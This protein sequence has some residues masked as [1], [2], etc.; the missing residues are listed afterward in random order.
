MDGHQRVCSS[1]VCGPQTELELL[2]RPEIR[3]TFRSFPRAPPCPSATTCLMN[4]LSSGYEVLEVREEPNVVVA[5]PR[6]F[7]ALLIVV[8]RRGMWPQYKVRKH[9]SHCAGV[10][11]HSS[12]M[13][14]QPPPPPPFRSPMAYLGIV[15]H[16]PLFPSRRFPNTRPGDFVPPPLSQSYPSWGS[17]PLPPSATA[18][19]QHAPQSSFLSAHME[20]CVSASV[21]TD[22]CSHAGRTG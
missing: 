9:Y 11:S 21:P 14:L 4:R 10:V 18:S 3:V 17:E 13:T 15:C 6:K 1:S 2:G 7:I 5:L 20:Q 8:Q 12:P 16:L 19:L 22:Q